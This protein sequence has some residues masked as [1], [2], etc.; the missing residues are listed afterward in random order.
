MVMNGQ[1]FKL[2]SAKDVLAYVSRQ[3]T[4]F[5][6]L[7]SREEFEE[8]HIGRAFHLPIERI[9]AEDYCLARE[10]SYILYCNHGGV[11]MQAATFLGGG[12]VPVFTLVGGVEEYEIFMRSL[13]DRKQGK[14]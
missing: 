11:S 9:E 5:I 4:I 3:D 13:V 2:I 10:Y 7:R 1:G 6:D 8:K 14:L 12:E